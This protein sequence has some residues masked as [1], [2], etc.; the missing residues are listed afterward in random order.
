[1]SMSAKLIIST[2]IAKHATCI[3]PEFLNVFMKILETGEKE[4]TRPARS[5]RGQAGREETI[6]LV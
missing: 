4:G 2:A 5:K 3:P 1:M 6:L